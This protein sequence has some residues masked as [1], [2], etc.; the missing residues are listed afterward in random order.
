MVEL[1]KLIHT[2]HPS[3]SLIIIITPIPSENGSTDKYIKTVS[4]TISSITFH[5][6]PTIAIPP[7]FSFDIIDLNFGIPELYNPI[8]HN[9]LVATY[10]GTK[11]QLK[12]IAIG[13]ERSEQR[14]L[15]VVRDP[16]NESNSG[17]KELGLDAILPEGF[18]A[19]TGD[20]GLLVKNWAPQ[21][22]IL[23]HDCL[24]IEESMCEV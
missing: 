13:L 16:P 11:E 9:A 10:F 20:K 8:F 21:P 7:D 18:L 19:R 14:F 17:G 15:W 5:H 6:L 23:S 1:G 24:A 22:A 12:E 4:A 2:H 3:L